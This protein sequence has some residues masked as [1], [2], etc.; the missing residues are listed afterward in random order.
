MRLLTS[1]RLGVNTQ[2][3]PTAKR[4]I[5]HCTLI[6]AN[7]SMELFVLVKHTTSQEGFVANTAYERALLGVF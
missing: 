1:M 3:I 2:R 4:P 5:T 7:T 6:L